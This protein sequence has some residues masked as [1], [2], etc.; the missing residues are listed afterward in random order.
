MKIF[1]QKI[2]LLLLLATSGLL[3]QAQTIEV[4]VT[5]SGFGTQV[6]ANGSTTDATFLPDINS[7]LPITITIKNTGSSTL[8]MT[9][10][11]GKY[12]ALGGASTADFTIVESGLTGSIT[13][14]ASQTFTVNASSSETTGNGK[15][16]SISILSNDAAN[17]DY[18]GTIK[19]NIVKPATTATTKAADIGLS[20]YPN[21][22]AD[23]HFFI[24]TNNVAV[25]KVVVSNVSGVTQEFSTQEFRTSLKGL[26]L[27]QVYTDKGIV[28]EKVI[29]QE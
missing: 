9:K 1:I 12:I 23:G 7:V 18:M 8:T 17:A 10:T 22:S 27:V 11:A 3:V 24:T 25:N 2:G 6:I 15:T 14:G 13:A 26:L 16:V 29:I 20:L 28:S 5:V 21:P 19:Y 4:S